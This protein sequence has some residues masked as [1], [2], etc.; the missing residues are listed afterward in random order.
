M[1]MAQFR[2]ASLWWWMVD[3]LQ[4]KRLEG[5]KNGTF[6]ETPA[7]TRQVLQA[8]RREEE[9]KRRVLKQEQHEEESEE[10]PVKPV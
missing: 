6:T 8:R 7:G 4:T 2:I 3:G 1:L 9:V 5:V 10:A